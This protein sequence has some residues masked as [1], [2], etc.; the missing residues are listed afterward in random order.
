MFVVLRQAF[1][2][3]AVLYIVT[4]LW[5]R[6]ILAIWSAIVFV[7]VLFGSFTTS[8]RWLPG[9]DPISGKIQLHK[10]LLFLPYYGA[11]LLLMIGG[12]LISRTKRWASY[13]PVAPG[14]YVGDYYSSF[15]SEIAWGSIIDIT[16][17]LPRLGECKKY[18]NIQS[19]DGC[20]P[21]IDQISEAVRF[22]KNAPRPLLIHCA[23]GKGRSATIASACLR[24]LGV[25]DSI[26]EAIKL[27]K[28]G[29]PQTSVNSRMRRV[30]EQWEESYSNSKVK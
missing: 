27:I 23:H 19:W 2:T 22:A 8:L 7:L 24:A 18:L 12:K 21:S 17:E 1:V 14:I 30:L 11:V 3:A 26:I 16:N 5:A 29:R 9:K 6:Y 25:C 15:R 10:A 28:L 4:H 13:S 20:P